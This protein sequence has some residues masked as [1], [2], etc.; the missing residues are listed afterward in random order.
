MEDFNKEKGQI[1]KIRTVKN[2]AEASNHIIIGKVISCNE[3]FVK[4]NCRTYHF[5]KHAHSP[6]DIKVGNVMDR[7][8]PWNRVEIINQLN[9]KFD[10][11]NA[12]L[13]A[14]SDT[15]VDLADDM[16]NYLMVSAHEKNY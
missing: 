4:L 9:D 14:A 8:I 15:Q 16:M 13:I 5:R 2:Y 11:I 7:I 6:N 1:W 3:A 10:Y 12:Q